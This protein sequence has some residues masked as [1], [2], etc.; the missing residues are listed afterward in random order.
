LIP[1]LAL[2]WLFFAR[3]ALA[4]TCTGQVVGVIDGDTIEVLHDKKTERIR[5]FV[6]DCR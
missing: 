6:I 3:P 4:E 1:L 2:S 5:L